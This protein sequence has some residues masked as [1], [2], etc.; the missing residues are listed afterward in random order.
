MQPNTACAGECIYDQFRL[1]YQVINLEYIK[2][3]SLSIVAVCY[4]PFNS[5]D[6]ESTLKFSTNN[7]NIPDKRLDIVMSIIESVIEN[8]KLPKD[9]LFKLVVKDSQAFYICS[10]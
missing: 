7:F 1:Q 10:V 6:K 9:K 4:N 2:G 8:L 3:K 5:L